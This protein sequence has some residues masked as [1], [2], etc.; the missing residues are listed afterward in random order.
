MYL[1][2]R[3]WGNGSAGDV[4]VTIES[5]EFPEPIEKVGWEQWP[6]YS[7]G[8]QGDTPEQLASQIS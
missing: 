1:E 3:A 6:S 5:S 8:R 7:P 2:I 4:L